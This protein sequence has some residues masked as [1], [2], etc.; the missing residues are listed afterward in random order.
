VRVA[1]GDA[2]IDGISRKFRVN[3]PAYVGQVGQRAVAFAVE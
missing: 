2:A 1:F 3:A